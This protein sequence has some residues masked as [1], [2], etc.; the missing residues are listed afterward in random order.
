MKYAC[1]GS[2][3]PKG[4]TTSFQEF[5][6]RVL[7]PLASI[8]LYLFRSLETFADGKGNRLE[9]LTRGGTECVT[10]SFKRPAKTA[11]ELGSRR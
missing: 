7:L 10:E 4:R 1:S 2:G 11:S 8:P 5:V 6:P 9:W 3:K